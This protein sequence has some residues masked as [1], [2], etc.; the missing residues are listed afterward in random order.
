[1][2]CCFCLVKDITWLCRE[3]WLIARCLL[4]LSLQDYSLCQFPPT[5]LALA[6]LQAADEIHAKHMRAGAVYYGGYSRYNINL[7]NP[8]GSY[9]F[10]QEEK[11]HSCFP[12]SNH[13]V[14]YT[15]WNL[16]SQLKKFLNY[17]DKT[18]VCY[19]CQKY[20]IQLLCQSIGPS[21]LRCF[22][23]IFHQERAVFSTG[24]PLRSVSQ[25]CG[26]YPMC[27]CR[28][29][30]IWTGY[31]RGT[32]TTVSRSCDSSEDCGHRYTYTGRL[33]VHLYCYCSV[34]KDGTALVNIVEMKNTV[35]VWF[36]NVRNYLVRVTGSLGLCDNYVLIFY[37]R[38]CNIVT[39]CNAHPKR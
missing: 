17:Y 34:T 7:Q 31:M 39:P 14:Y 3:S 15:C 35:I 11:E 29:F 22:M 38:S 21:H 23:A 6:A 4:E 1:M 18:A 32:L 16:A 28:A 24:K 20:G 2:S 10:Q 8:E 36:Y 27:G 9:N 5:L 33:N 25:R 30:Q 26:C 12:S 19:G 13:A 37:F